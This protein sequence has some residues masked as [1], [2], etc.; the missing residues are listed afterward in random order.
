VHASQLTLHWAGA[1]QIAPRLVAAA[2]ADRRGRWAP[3]DSTDRR[4]ESA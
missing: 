3:D 4:E 2:R 1:P